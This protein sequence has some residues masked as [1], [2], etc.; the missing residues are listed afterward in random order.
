M[1][2]KK[3]QEEKIQFSLP[4]NRR[5]LKYIAV[6]LVMLALAYVIVTEPEKISRFIS[7]V[8]SVFSP[9]I[10]G[11]CIAYV[12]NLLMKPLER[13]W[14][15]IW[16]K[17]KSQKVVS[18]LSRPVCLVLSLLI[19][20]GAIFAIVFMVIP[21][22]KETI[23]SFADNVPQYAKTVEQWYNTVV[24]FLARY[25]FELPEI[26]LDTAKITEI[27]KD[28]ISSYGN[29]VLNTTVNLTTSI[30]SV[31]VDLILGVV[32]SIYALAQKENL[33]RQANKIVR[34]LFKPD[35]AKKLID[36]T[37]M[38]NDIFT[39]FVTGQ[40]TEAC[41]IGILCFIGMLI[42]GMPYAAIISVLI[43][44]TALIP[45]FGAFIG[46]GI[47][48][49]LI[50]LENPLKA[51]WFVVFIIVL[52]QLEGNLIYPRVVGKS[53]GLPGIWVLTAVTIGGGLFGILGMLF[54]VPVCSV[55]YV[56]F[57][58]FVNNR[59]KDEDTQTEIQEQIEEKTE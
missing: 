22:F 15:F 8:L 57:K 10:I 12:V 59:V 18:K 14:T 34:A 29:N 24:D 42:F 40:L 13:F 6:I 53:V 45:I 16:K 36:F 51:F 48:A 54:S 55:L 52:Q 27:A 37:A 17:L 3:T 39:R 1:K 25:N 43:G 56:L 30:V 31:V 38:T 50:L 5:S 41:I 9:F 23:V 2:D 28:I 35:N 46:T 47:G 20:F 26:A 44:F 33:T 32:F 7:G 49:F 19:V 21:A 11:F 58:K 4:L